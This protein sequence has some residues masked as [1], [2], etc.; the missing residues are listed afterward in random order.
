MLRLSRQSSLGRGALGSGRRVQQSGGSNFPTADCCFDGERLLAAI[1]FYFGIWSWPIKHGPSTTT[2][3]A[4]AAQARRV[5]WSARLVE[6][7][8]KR[9][10]LCGA[11]VFV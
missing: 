1:T 7:V 4:S 8:L 6:L 5:S 11:R 9:L 3:A 2:T 10:R